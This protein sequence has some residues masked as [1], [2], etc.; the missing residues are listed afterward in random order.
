M[1]GEKKQLRA[2]VENLVAKLEA[3]Q[4]RSFRY[5]QRISELEELLHRGAGMMA[6]LRVQ[7]TSAKE[8]IARVRSA[9]ADVPLVNT[10]GLPC[11]R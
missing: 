5:C 1:F 4:G 2:R 10:E 3:E 6:D 9:V 11:S 8:T 7:L